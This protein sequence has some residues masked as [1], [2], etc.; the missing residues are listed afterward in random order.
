[1]TIDITSYKKNGFLLFKN[2]FDPDE[3]HK[4]LIEAKK[5]FYAQ[6]VQKGYVNVPFEKLDE[7]KFNELMYRL[8]AEDLDCL[9]NCGKQVQH[10]ISLHSLSINKKIIELLHAAGLSN[11][12][13]STRPVMYFN[14]PKLAKQK[15]FYKV[16]AHQDWRSMQ[17]SLNAVVIWLPLV[18]I[19]RA[20]GALEI[21]P[22]SHLTGLRTDHIEN[23]F[24]M[25]KL[26]EEEEKKM[27]SVEVQAGDALLFSS[28]LIQQRGEN[29]TDEPR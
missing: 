7:K 20:L 8:S 5:V 25:V 1:M 19:N 16:D 24:G 13:I 23:G 10:L 11:P 27:I 3:V 17:G 26:N 9:S 28:L 21:L 15:V 2:F 12:T 4:I 6:F 22:G 18:D 14:H 29:S